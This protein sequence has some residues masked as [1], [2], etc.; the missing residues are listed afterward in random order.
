MPWV[1]AHT[2][3]NGKMTGE[4]RGFVE[5]SLAEIWIDAHRNS[6]DNDPRWRAF[7]EQNYDWHIVEYHEDDTFT[8]LY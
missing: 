2:V 7:K 5:R 6:R 8:I 4:M 1:H 3:K